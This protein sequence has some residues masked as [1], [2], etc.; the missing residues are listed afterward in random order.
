MRQVAEQLAD[1]VNYAAGRL[2]ALTESEAA[3]KTAP[4]E[5]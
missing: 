3:Y 4:E 2:L 1:V 5:W